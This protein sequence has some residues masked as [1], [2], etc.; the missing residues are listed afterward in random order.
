MWPTVLNEFDSSDIA[1]CFYAGQIPKILVR[2]IFRS[3][4]NE[5]IILLQGWPTVAHC[6][7]FGALHV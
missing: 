1:Y 4:I 5:S 3:L 2:N 6:A 7:K